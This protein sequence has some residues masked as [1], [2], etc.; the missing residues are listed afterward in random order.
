MRTAAQA[1][2]ASTGASVASTGAAVATSNEAMI[3]LSAFAHY[4]P[5]STPLAVNHQSQFVAATIS[6]NLAKGKSL[7]DA[8]AAIHRAEDEH[9]HARQSHPRFCRR[10][11]CSSRSRSATRSSWSIAALAAI[12]IVLGVLYESFIHPI[13][14]LSTLP[15]AGVGAVLALMAFGM[16]FTIIALIGVILLIGIVKKNAILMIDFALQAEREGGMDTPRCDLPRGRAC[17]SARS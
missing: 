12:Y 8:Q 4:A 3:P 6:F 10:R 5:G 16:P 13:T 7:S 14:I 17:A 9:P 15:S 2:I 1:T 11:R